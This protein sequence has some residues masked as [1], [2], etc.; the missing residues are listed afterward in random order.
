[1][2]DFD[3]CNGDNAVSVKLNGPANYTLDAGDT[4]F[5]CLEDDHCVQGQQLAV[6]AS[7][8]GSPTSSPSPRQ[9]ANGPS[10]SNTPPPPPEQSFAARVVNISFIV[11]MSL[12][13]A[14][15][16]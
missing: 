7:A 4:Y 6:K 11:S 5:I 10:S 3:S 2:D 12:V 13:I 8:T 1:M 15:F 9:F 14:N 16:F